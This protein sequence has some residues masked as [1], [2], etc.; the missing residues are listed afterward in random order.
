MSIFSF[1]KNIVTVINEMTVTILM[2]PAV[3]IRSAT[4][5]QVIEQAITQRNE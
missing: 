1:D 3:A 5:L 4:N 2:A